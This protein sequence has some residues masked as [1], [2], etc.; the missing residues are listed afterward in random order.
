MKLK[1]ENIKLTANQRLHQ[2]DVPIIAI[3][4]GIACGKSTV[5]D[6]LASLGHFVINADQLVKEIYQTP[7]AL[8]FIK[9]NCPNAFSSN[10]IDFKILRQEVFNNAELKDKIAKL[11][12]R[13]IL[14]KKSKTTFPIIS[15][16]FYVDFK[17]DIRNNT[18]ESIRSTFDFD[19]VSQ[20]FN[21][22]NDQLSTDFNYKDRSQKPAVSLSYRKE[23]WTASFTTG[24]V[25]R[26]LENSDRLRPQLSLKQDFEALELDSNFNYQFSPSSSMYMGY[27]LDNTPPQISQLQPFQDVSDP[28]NTITGNPNLEPSNNHG[29]YMGFNSFDFQKGKGFNIYANA[30]LNNNQVVSKTTI[31]ENFVRNTTYENVNGSYSMYI[32]AN[33]NSS[34]KIDSLKTIKYRL[35]LWTNTNRNINFNNDVKYAS[36]YTSLTPNGSITFNW[37]KVLEIVPNYRLSFTK[38]VFDLDDFDDQEFIRHSLGLRTATFVPKKLEWRNDINFIYNANVAPG[39]QKSAWFW[40]STLAYSVLKEQG[41]VTLKVYD[42]LNQNTNAQRTATA[43]YIQDSQSTVLQQYFMVSFSWKFNS[44]GKQGEV[45]RGGMYFF[46]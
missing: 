38:N 2:C 17:Y 28:L 31:D 34:F 6:H 32:G 29:L 35:G 11:N 14:V 18:R 5:S 1:V 27:Y 24:Y 3:T 37:N 7:E 19:E 46:D 44:L 33:Y 41:T 30:D 42:L 25:F 39:F 22:F 8:K 13:P 23:K 15:K 20:E 36:T 21:E 43:N 9:N 40:N 26:T 10:Q 12:T 16:K 45:G 4:G